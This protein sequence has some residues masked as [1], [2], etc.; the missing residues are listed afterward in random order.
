MVFGLRVLVVCVGVALGVV[1][2]LE[3]E[4]APIEWKDDD[5]VAAGFGKAGADGVAAGFI[6]N[7]AVFEGQAA[8]AHAV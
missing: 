7:A 6:L 3:A 2:A 1:V 4:A 5:D 8:D